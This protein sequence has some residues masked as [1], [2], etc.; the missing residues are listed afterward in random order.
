MQLR[1]SAA[2]PVAY[3]GIL[4]FGD[5]L[6]RFIV[7]NLLPGYFDAQYEDV[8]LLGIG[9][10]LGMLV[11]PSGPER[12]TIVFSSG[13]GLGSAK[14]GYGVAPRSNSNLDVVCVRG[15]YTAA[16]MGLPASKAVVDGA[17]LLRH[18]ITDAAPPG[19]APVFVPHMWSVL[20]GGGAWERVC[21]EAGLRYI[22]PLTGDIFGTI[23]AIRGAPFV[24][25]EAMHA[26]IVAET[27]GVPW[28]AVATNRTIN[29][30]KWQD[31]CRSMGHAYSPV[32]LP[33][34]FASENVTKEIARRLQRS[35]CPMPLVKAARAYERTVG[36]RRFRD[37]HAGLKAIMT[38]SD[39]VQPDERLL[40]TRLDQLF[41]CL[42][43]IRARYP[44]A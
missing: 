35:H 20:A 18:L 41:T 14:G 2:D 38:S 12:Q 40:A 3:P 30:F 36:A 33:K 43:D 23:D 42:D 16:A 37:A 15:P 28:I 34:L 17:V 27:F 10:I 21:R 22:D 31:W 29:E 1:Y 13:L 25:A 24:V 6:N 26:A 19:S 44:L 11:P 7:P 5:E 4:N 32:H 39:F 8:D 9:T